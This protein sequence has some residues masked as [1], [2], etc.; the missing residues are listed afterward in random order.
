[1]ETNLRSRLERR[2]LGFIFL[3]QLLSSS[4]GTNSSNK[5][6]VYQKSRK[7]VF[8]LMRGFEKELYSFMCTLGWIMD[9]TRTAADKSH[10]FKVEHSL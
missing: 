7:A 2:S 1:M 5:L 8:P 10:S 4:K 9:F 3:L 6:F